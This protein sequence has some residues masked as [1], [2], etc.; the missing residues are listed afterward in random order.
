M[1]AF[2][3]WI[4]EDLQRL[5]RLVNAKLLPSGSRVNFFYR[6]WQPDGPIETVATF[7]YADQRKNVATRDKYD[8]DDADKIV[9]LVN[10][11]IGSAQPV[12]KWTEDLSEADRL[13]WG[14]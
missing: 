2:K 10:E 14:E 8:D 12:S 11:W 9:Q 4:D 1:K 13:N 7:Q 5:E 3:T 6:L